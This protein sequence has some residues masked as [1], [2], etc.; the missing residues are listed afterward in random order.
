MYCPYCGG[1]DSR[2]VN[3]RE[4][5]DAVRRRRECLSCSR[6]FTTFERLETTLLVVKRDGRREQFDR[7]KLFE[8]VRKAC[9]KRPISVAQIDE[10]RH[11]C[12]K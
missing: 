10:L 2:V 6:R 5:V 1:A 9:H 4:L 3:S 11:T 12:R 8:G 7:R